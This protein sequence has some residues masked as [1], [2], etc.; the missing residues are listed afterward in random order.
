MRKVPVQSL[1][2]SKL[3]CAVDISYIDLVRLHHNNDIIHS[4]L[5]F[6]VADTEFVFIEKVG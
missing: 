3:S 6:V 4:N 5:L 2:C 1:S